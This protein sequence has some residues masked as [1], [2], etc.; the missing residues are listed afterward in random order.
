M[1]QT[2]HQTGQKGVVLILLGYIIWGLF[3]LYWVLLKHVNALEV[4]AHRMVWSVPV[5]IV[6]IS[7][8]KAWRTNFF[9]A[10]KDKKELG[11]LFITSILISINWGVYILAVNYDRIVEASMGYFLSPLIHVLGGFFVFKERITGLKLLAVICAASGVFYYVASVDGFPWIG[12]VLGFSFASYGILRKKIKTT[13][14][15]GLLIETILLVPFSLGFLIYLQWTNQAAFLNTSVM[16]DVWLILAGA[17]TVVPL[18]LFT[19]GARL[20]SMTTT[21]ILFYI[22]PTLQFLVGVWLFKEAI[23]HNQLL[24]FMGIWLGLLLYTIA[25]L[26]RKKE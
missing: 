4:L 14:V 13:A 15:S 23:N 6:F 24:G 2:I 11:W 18:V 26:Q 20:L 9:S 19:S 16:T 1:K 3:P 10:L 25:L 21:G 22:T 8:V 12:L 7:L 5:L 17:V